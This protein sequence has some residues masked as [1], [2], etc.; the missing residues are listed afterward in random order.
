MNPSDL[1]GVGIQVSR[2]ETKNSAK[3]NGKIDSFVIRKKREDVV[4][5]DNC[6]CE[7]STSSDTRF[8]VPVAENEESG[9]KTPDVST[10]NEA[11]YDV[12][13]SQVSIR[14]GAF[15]SPPPPCS[16]VGPMRR[17]RAGG[18]SVCGANLAAC[19]A[20]RPTKHRR[21]FDYTIHLQFSSS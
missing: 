13:L 9:S 16:N 11:E 18:C 2:L 19:I 12:S 3:L 20:I 7:P 15:D 5:L 1:R 14:D 6:A 8:N 17:S 4:S 10:F 21:A